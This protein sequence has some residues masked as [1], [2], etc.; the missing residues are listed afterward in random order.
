M[1]YK[2]SK[3]TEL[4]KT[5]TDLRKKMDK[6]QKQAKE[7][8]IEFGGTTAATN[9]RHLAG[10]IDAVEFKEKPDGWRSVGN[11]WQNLYYPKADKKNKE[12]HEKIQALPVLEFKELNDAVGFTGN[13][14]VCTDNGF[15]FIKTV[16]MQWH[17]DFI[18]MEVAEKTKYTPIKSVEEI[19]GS[20][21][22]KLSKRI[23][24]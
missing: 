5:L 17:K 23:K 7:L 6:V 24:N 19:L 10:G 8:A 20:E 13:Q 16:G 18:L 3:G 22:D 12:I 4:F 9:G 14:S 2:I 11:S 21:F 15:S 1:K